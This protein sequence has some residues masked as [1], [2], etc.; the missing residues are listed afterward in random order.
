MTNR[1]AIILAATAACALALD[2]T[3]LGGEGSRL[4]ARKFIDLINYVAI[5][6]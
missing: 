3:L 6:R 5:W 2:F 1:I 4:L